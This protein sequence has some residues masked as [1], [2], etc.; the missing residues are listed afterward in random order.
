[1]ARFNR[2]A[3]VGVTEHILHRGNNRQDCFVEEEDMKAYLSW[4]TEYSVKY[5][6]DVHAW[7]L[8]SNHV[9]LLCTPHEPEAISKMMQSM[10]RMY[11]RYFNNTYQ[12]SGTLWEGRYK[13]CLIESKAYLLE[14]YRYIELNPVRAG[15]VN[16]PSEYFWSS[17]QCNGFGKKSQLQTPHE[18]Y[19]ALGRSKKK[20]LENYQLLLD[21]DVEE[22]LLCDIRKSINKGLALG[23]VRFTNQIEK[24]TGKRVTQAQRG[25]PRNK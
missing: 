16:E 20:R 23:S 11:V 21:I 3:P 7:V 12:R 13:S 19:K 9:H 1:M 15:M 4:L 25:R 24:L 10:G 8:M 18:L 6:V 22:V 5:K 2:I 17:Y 14:L